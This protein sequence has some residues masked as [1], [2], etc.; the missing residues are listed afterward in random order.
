LICWS[1]MDSILNTTLYELQAVSYVKAGFLAL[2][3]YDFFLSLP[4]E[5]SY[6]WFSK[7][8]L[9]KILYFITRYLPFVDTTLTVIETLHSINN[10]MSCSHSTTLVT[11]CAG[12]GIGISAFMLMIRTCVMFDNSRKVLGTFALLWIVISALNIWAAI[13][14]T[15]VQVP[16]DIPEVPLCFLSKESN[17]GL[18]CYI[19]LLAGETVVV[20][21]TLWKGFQNYFLMGFFEATTKLS[22]NFYRDGVLFYLFVLPFTIGNVVVL[23]RAPPGLQLLLDTPLRVM[24]SILCCR[25][26]IHIRVI[27]DDSAF[28]DGNDRE[29]KNEDNLGDLLAQRVHNSYS[30][31]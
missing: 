13:N 1:N 21:L 10:I 7:W 5:I 28:V 29:I 3:T 8:G 6:I 25:L 2:L 19:S 26:I 31:V 16:F 11:I 22:V 17:I 18:I 20:A 15:Q 24:H 30:Q 12:V 27:A 23:L 14:W 9:V 4:H